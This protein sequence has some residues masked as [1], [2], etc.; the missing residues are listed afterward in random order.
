MG[1]TG[2]PKV[3]GGVEGY[4]RMDTLGEHEKSWIARGDVGVGVEECRGLRETTAMR[5]SR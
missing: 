4:G 5:Y 1:A 3:L 2:I